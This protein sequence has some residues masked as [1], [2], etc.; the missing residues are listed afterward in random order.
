MIIALTGHRSEDCEPEERVRERVRSALQSTPEQVDAVIC[1]MANGLD[2]WGG[3][4]AL[5]LG[6]PV[7]AARPCGTHGPRT[8]DVELYA[9]V[10]ENAE[11][12][13]VVTETDNYPGPWVYHKRNE[14]MVDNADAVL[15]YWSGKERGGT[16]A[17]IK[18]A[19]KVGKQIRNIYGKDL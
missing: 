16:Y 2:L 11:R 12:V 19:R 5:S 4:E 7:W 6:I 17:C 9:K 10:I 14:W 3:D 18:Y 1:G 15:A 8:S 13:V